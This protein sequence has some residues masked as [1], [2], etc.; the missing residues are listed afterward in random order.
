MT[1]QML[2][3]T[4]LKKHFGIQG[5]TM[6][7]NKGQYGAMLGYAGQ[8]GQCRVIFACNPPAS[9][10]CTGLVRP[11]PYL[12]CAWTR[13]AMALHWATLIRYLRRPQRK[14]NEAFYVSK[15]CTKM[16]AVFT[17]W[18]L[19]PRWLRRLASKQTYAGS[20]PTCSFC[21]F[22]RFSDFLKAS[23]AFQQRVAKLEPLYIL[24]IS[25]E[26]APILIPTSSYARLTLKIKYGK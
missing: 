24:F 1:L 15:I 18:T 2:F 16:N 6:Q 10:S 3:W 26:E 12:H 17:M 9:T 25:I 5:Y 7:G 11:T 4:R 8:C 23:R 14:I 20:N 21:L 19:W 22:S 13:S